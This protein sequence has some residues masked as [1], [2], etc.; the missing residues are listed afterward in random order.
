[1]NSKVIIS[2]LAAL[3]SVICMEPAQGSFR[4]PLSQEVIS[5]PRLSAHVPVMNAMC[6]GMQRPASESVSDV[7][8][9]LR[10]IRDDSSIAAIMADDRFSYASIAYTSALNTAS[11]WQQIIK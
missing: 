9:A 8:E 10:A 2:L 11:E 1:M 6:T 5:D 4:C 7:L 3:S